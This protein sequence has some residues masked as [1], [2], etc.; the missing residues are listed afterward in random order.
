MDC[1]FFTTN[2]FE[3]KSNQKRDY[4][5]LDSFVIFMCVEGTTKVSIG[6][7]TEIVA[8]GETILIPA[9]TDAV[10]FNSEG[11]KLLEVFI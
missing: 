7:K 5:N 3:V 10:T 11:S 1:D 2:I 4:S 6:N 9:N 8:M